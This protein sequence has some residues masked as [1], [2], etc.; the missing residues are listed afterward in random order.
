MSRTANN[1]FFKFSTIFFLLGI[2]LLDSCQTEEIVTSEQK[3]IIEAKRWFEEY[4]SKSNFNSLFENQE[5]LWENAKE[6]TLENGQTA[7]VVPVNDKLQIENYKGKKVLYLYPSEGLKNYEVTL[8]ELLPSAESLQELNSLKELSHFDGYII[9]WNLEKGF[10]ESTKFKNSTS[11]ASISGNEIL[12]EKTNNI[13]SK[14]TPDPPVASY[15]LGDV[16]I[17]NDFKNGG[18]GYSGNGYVYYVN[19]FGVSGGYTGSYFNSS[20]GSGASGGGIKAPTPLQIIDKLT[21]KSKCIND[22]LTKN[23]NNFVQKLLAN[24]AG[25]SNFDIKI[26]SVDKIDAKDVNGNLLQSNGETTYTREINIAISTSR[27]NDNSSLDVARTILHEYIHADIIR[28]L[29]TENNIPGTLDFNLIYQKYGSQHGTMAALYLSSMKEALKEFNK[30][31]LP[32][33]YKN[34]TDYYG[35]EPSDAFY[36]ALAWSGLKENNVQAWTNLTAQQQQDINNLA[37]R[38]TQ[39][40]KTAN[41]PQ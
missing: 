4:Q 37:A 15:C 27:A 28:K 12:K 26:V 2:L 41:C 30:T 20:H 8:Y 16:I 40:S 21:G 38:V 5:Y 14:A 34:Y 18:S 36:E 22:L 11:V 19:S 7:I 9:A 10:I 13:F 6:E 33:D 39:M 31:V 25:T 35:E 1:F 3:T 29:Y 17:C 24:F 32:N 23:G